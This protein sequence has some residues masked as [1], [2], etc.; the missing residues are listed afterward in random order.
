[1]STPDSATER[2]AA[3]DR[4]GDRDARGRGRQP[5]PQRDRPALPGARVP[6]E[7]EMTPTRLAELSDLTSGAVTGVLDR[8]E[9]AGF[10]RRESDP[11]DR[12]R[13]LVRVDPE[14]LR[15]AR[16]AVRADHRARG[17]R[18]AAAVSPAV[19]A[20]ADAYLAAVADALGSEADRLRVA[21]YGGILDDA[22]R[23]PIGEV[24]RARLV[25]A[26][27]RAADQ[28][29]RVRRSASR[30]GW[31][32]RPPRRGLRSAPRSPAASSSA[33]SFDRPAA[34]R[35]HQ[36]RHRDDALSPPRR[37]HPQPR[38]RRRPPPEPRRGRSRSR[39]ASPTSRRTCARSLARA[40]R[41]AAA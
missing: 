26:H 13:L 18:P 28:P 32:R 10:V 16:G 25:A 4:R 9:R 21:T 1:M 36:R 34:G 6:S 38:D 30:C 15:R 19:A 3:P 8:L 29:R 31:S 27:R 37:R 20:E 41:L 12:R 17:C 23:V 35:A 7:P 33:P 39:T 5:R 24:A 22:Y 14:R 11:N 2:A 40:Q